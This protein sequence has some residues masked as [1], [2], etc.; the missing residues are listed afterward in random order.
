MS[1]SFEIQSNSAEVAK[2]LR[3]K[4]QKDVPFVTS[5]AL[6]TTLRKVRDKDLTSS[7]G[8]V[9]EARNKAFMQQLLWIA[10]SNKRQARTYGAV[11]G[12]IQEKMAPAPPGTLAKRGKI[13]D[14]SFMR[15]HVTG[16]IKSPHRRALAIPMSGAV[17]RNKTG[18]ITKSQK[19]KQIIDSKK[20][21]RSGNLIMRRRTKKK[22]EVMYHLAPRARIDK[23]WNPYG[24]ARAGVHMRFRREFAR[25]WIAT[26]RRG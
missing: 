23:R 4:I 1:V 12:S 9:F 16:G 7:Y 18:S 19:P 10:Y 24:V 13:A 15:R 11:V 5:K 8:M 26:L 14:T 2:R 22:V 25:E 3:D 6:N 17:R 21:F 20:G